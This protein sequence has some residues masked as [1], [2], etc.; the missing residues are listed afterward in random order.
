MT[1]Q[2]YLDF[3]KIKKQSPAYLFSRKY[4][5]LMIFFLGGAAFKIHLWSILP[6]ELQSFPQTVCGPIATL[7]VSGF[8]SIAGQGESPLFFPSHF[9][10]SSLPQV[11]CLKQNCSIR[12]T[13]FQAKYQFIEVICT[14]VVIF[15]ARHFLQS[16]HFVLFVVLF[17]IYFDWRKKKRALISSFQIFSWT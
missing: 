14:N 3:K 15:T 12:H 9:S 4:Q 17:V 10:I 7:N 11:S 1:A 5:Q 2:H 16:L 13:G 8:F 6:V